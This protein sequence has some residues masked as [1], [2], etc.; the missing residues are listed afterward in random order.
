MPVPCL[1]LPALGFLSILIE[2][3]LYTQLFFILF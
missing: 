1:S 2:L 3:F